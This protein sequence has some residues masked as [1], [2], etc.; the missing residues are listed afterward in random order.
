[1]EIRFTEHAM[2]KLP[3]REIPMDNLTKTIKCPDSTRKDR[4]DPALV[5]MIKKID[6]K[7]LR[8]IGKWT[9]AENFLVISAFYDRRLLR[10]GIHD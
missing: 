3:A 4:L 1:M 7:Y 6:E 9:D 5:H 2:E 10:G 8:V